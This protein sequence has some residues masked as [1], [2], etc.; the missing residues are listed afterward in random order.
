[1]TISTTT[2]LYVSPYGTWP[3]SIPG[4]SSKLTNDGIA[5]LTAIVTASGICTGTV[6]FN[7][8]VTVPIVDNIARLTFDL[9]I[10][11]SGA[12]PTFTAAY[13]GDSVYSSSTGSNT[14][15]ISSGLSANGLWVSQ[16]SNSGAFDYTKEFRN[17]AR[18]LETI[19][20]NSSEIR[21]YIGNISKL[22]S[23]V[24]ISAN[25][26]SISSNS[27]LN[28]ASN[29]GIRTM[30]GYDWMG[31]LSM[32]NYYVQ[33]GNAIDTTA[34]ASATNQIL[35]AV[36]LQTL[37]NNIVKDTATNLATVVLLKGQAGFATD[38]NVLKY[39]DGTTVWSSLPTASAT[40]VS[41]Y[42]TFT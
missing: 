28:L 31:A 4:G 1:M 30:G 16:S 9:S 23:N 27:M 12:T 34:S 40:A 37:N 5:T 17:M 42:K 8:S 6:K 22:L 20:V 2:A 11:S 7:D 32:V 33:Q 18:A 25:S 21:N 14:V 36:Q 41:N 35:S 19:A 26:I 10:Y 24:A 38:T 29:G 39:G 13:S 3:D 15:T